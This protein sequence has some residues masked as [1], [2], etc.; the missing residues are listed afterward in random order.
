[1]Q[2]P[3]HPKGFLITL[4]AR[5]NFMPRPRKRESPCR[6]PH[7]I[8]SPP[9]A[10]NLEAAG[11]AS[12]HAEAIID[13]MRQAGGEPITTKAAL[14]GLRAELKA[15]LYRALWMQAGGIIGLTVALVKLL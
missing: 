13:A 6:L 3:V 4:Q 15:N 5:A 7:S 2:L 11:I 10:S 14:D 1:M 9:P 8:P 12:T